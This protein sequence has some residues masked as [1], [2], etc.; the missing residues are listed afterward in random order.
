MDRAQFAPGSESGCSRRGYHEG[1][2]TLQ[3]QAFQVMLH[4]SYPPLPY[5]RVWRLDEQYP[6]KLGNLRGDPPNLGFPCFGE[7]LLIRTEMG[8]TEKVLLLPP[9]GNHLLEWRADG[10]PVSLGEW[11][12]P[13]PVLVVI[14]GK[15]M[16]K[17]ADTFREESYGVTGERLLAAGAGIRCDRAVPLNVGGGVLGARVLSRSCGLGGRTFSDRVMALLLGSLRN[18]VSIR[19]RGSADS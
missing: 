8:C 13:K 3:L 7:L 4:S 14:R 16:K 10:G 19:D 6:P 12:R 15:L 5:R 9:V 1:R 18:L 17:I 11:L 2:R